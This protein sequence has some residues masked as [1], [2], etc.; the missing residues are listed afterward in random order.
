[1]KIHFI[2]ED[3]NREISILDAIVLLGEET[4]K[5]IFL[6]RKEKAIAVDCDYVVKFEF[7]KEELK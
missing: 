1:M 7:E 3:E 5:P 6:N 2:G 4:V